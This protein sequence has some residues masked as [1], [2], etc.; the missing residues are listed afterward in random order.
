MVS[1]LAISFTTTKQPAPCYTDK[2]PAGI[3]LAAQKWQL[4]IPNV[5]KVDFTTH[6]C[7]DEKTTRFGNWPM[8]DTTKKNYEG[9]IRQFWRFCAIVGDYESMLLLL[10]NPPKHSPAIRAD[11]LEQ[12]MRFKRVDPQTPLLQ[13]RVGNDDAV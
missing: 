4:K 7:M 11:T 3:K 1:Q 13:E 10:K 12:F 8:A 2:I 5:E 9:H 6:E